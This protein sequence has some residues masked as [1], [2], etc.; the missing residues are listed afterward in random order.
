MK[1]NA[2]LIASALV[3]ASVPAFADGTVDGGNIFGILKVESKTADTIVAVPWC[4]C[5]TNDNGAVAISNIVKTANLTVGDT[6]CALDSNRDKINTWTLTSGAG[7]VLYWESQKQVVESGVVENS[8]SAAQA[9]AAR[10][11]AIILHRQNPTNSVGNANAFYLY[12]QVGSRDVTTTPIAA[13]ESAPAYT[14]IAPPST[15]DVNLLQSGVLTD[16][17]NGDSIVVRFDNGVNREF[18]YNGSSWV[19][20]KRTYNPKAETAALAY[21][22]T[23]YPTNSITLKCGTGA[24]YISRGAS[25]PTIAWPQVP[26]K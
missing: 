13:T 12:G 2:F 20:T 10:G 9:H 1:K 17:P 4:E 25:V 6:L 21:T 8:I 23:E 22:I 3:C 18:K 7:N 11:T 26:T 15:N 5:A 19:Y 14:L 16:V 24:W